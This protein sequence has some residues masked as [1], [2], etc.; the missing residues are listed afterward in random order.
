VAGLKRNIMF[1]VKLLSS[2]LIL[3][4]LLMGVSRIIVLNS[5]SSKL[6]DL[7]EAHFEKIAIVFGAGLRRDGTPTAILR[8]RIKTAVDLYQSG[9]VEKILMSGDN[10]EIGYNEPAAM[11][12]YA[13]QLGVPEDM[14]VLDYAGRRTYDTCYRAKHIFGLTDAILVTQSFHLPRAIYTC[15]ALGM[16]AIGVIANNQT[17]RKSSLFYWNVRELF[18]TLTALWDVHISHPVPILGEK[19]PIFDQ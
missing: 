13:V 16:K 1:I 5:T 12:N 2:V 17:Y 10:R 6:V 14:I 3:V 4:I 19:E 11:M 7:D 18:A 8:D 9:K 15:N